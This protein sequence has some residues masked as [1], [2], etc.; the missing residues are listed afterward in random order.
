MGV[1]QTSKKKLDAY[2]SV[3]TASVEYSSM[4]VEEENDQKQ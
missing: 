1:C 4:H 3:A 2:Q